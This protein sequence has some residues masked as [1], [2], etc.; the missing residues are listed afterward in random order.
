[1][2]WAKVARFGFDELEIDRV[3]PIALCGTNEIDNLRWL[4]GQHNRLVAWRMGLGGPGAADS[5]QAVDRK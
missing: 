5:P 3:L 1:M 4:C 2:C